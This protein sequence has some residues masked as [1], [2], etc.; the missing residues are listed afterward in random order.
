[1]SKVIH[2]PGLV[3][4]DDHGPN[5]AT[6]TVE[7]LRTGYGMTLGNSLRRVLLSSISGSAITSFK[8]EGTSHEFTTLPYV[9]EDAVEIMLNLKSIRFRA[10]TSDPQTLRIDKKGKGVV[11]GSDIEKNA[12]IEV[13]NPKHVIANLD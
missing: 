2:T 7:P 8:I 9:K 6:F 13:V 12:D 10:F 4:I 11:T 3:N 5:S 1:M